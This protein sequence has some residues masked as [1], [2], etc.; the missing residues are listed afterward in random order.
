MDPG[1][2]SDELARVGQFWACRLGA[3]PDAFLR[4][5][6]AFVSREEPRVVMVSIGPGLA[7]VGPPRVRRAVLALA[8]AE[9]RQLPAVVSHLQALGAEL[10]GEAL[11]MYLPARHFQPF[12]GRVQPATSADVA[13]ILDRAAPDD[14]AEASL[15]APVQ[16]VVSLTARGEPASLAR[17]E[18]WDGEVAQLSLLTA[19]PHRGSGYATVAA[20]AV[21]GGAL[22]QGLLPQWRVRVGHRASEQVGRR[23]GFL[24]AGRQLVI[25][26]PAP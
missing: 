2:R 18:I 3:P 15:S 9:P 25:S 16:S 8:A 26:L 10:V 1:L 22:D 19:A 12:P 5:G 13:H 23:L 7:V 17:L 21:A 6:V 24:P 4:A 11:L 14:I 20:S